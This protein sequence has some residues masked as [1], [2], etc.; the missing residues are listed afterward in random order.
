MIKTSRKK[1]LGNH[2][3]DRTGAIVVAPDADSAEGR[4]GKPIEVL[5]KRRTLWV[6]R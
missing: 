3:D 1:A 4:A 6:W 2:G 5:A